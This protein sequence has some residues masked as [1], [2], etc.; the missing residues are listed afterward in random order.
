MKSGGED[1]LPGVDGGSAERGWVTDLQRFFDIFE[2][3]RLALDVFTVVEDGRL[4]ARVKSEYPGINQTYER[5]QEDSLQGRPQI[6]SLPAREAL[7]EVLVRIS[8]QRYQ[9][10]SAPRQYVEEAR[11]EPDPQRRIDLYQKAEQ[12]I[13][14]DAAW[15]PLW[16]R[17]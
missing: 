11:T 8:L 2:D 17:P 3:R 4:D 13:I 5:V 9:G 1:D 6:E 16:R 7:L 15:L 10:L 12:I 14:S